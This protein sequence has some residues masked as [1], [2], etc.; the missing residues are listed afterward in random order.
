[1]AGVRIRIRTRMAS[2]SHPL[3]VPPRLAGEP[4]GPR[5]PHAPRA[6]AAAAWRSPPGR[7]CGVRAFAG[8]ASAVTAGPVRDA[9]DSLLRDRSD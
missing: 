1:V 4:A 5:A 2:V 8:A 7:A 6:R 9:A 3:P